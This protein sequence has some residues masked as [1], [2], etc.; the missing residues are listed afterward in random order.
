MLYVINVKPRTSGELTFLT[1]AS[2]G[3]TVDF[4]QCSLSS[5]TIN[6]VQETISIRCVGVVGVLKPKL[7][8]FELQILWLNQTR[9][10]PGQFTAIRTRLWYSN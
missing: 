6:K 7:G 3:L 2:T 8:V 1:G 10:I 4:K 9:T 5:T